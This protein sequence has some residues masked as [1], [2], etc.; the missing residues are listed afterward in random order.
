MKKKILSVL[1]VLTLIF[2]LSACGSK[3]DSNSGSSKDST[4]ITIG[5]NDWP[6]SYWWLAVN[7]L[8]YFKE[9]GVD[10]DV[11]LFSNY[12]DGLS[13]LNSGKIDL[14]VPGLADIIPGF[15][16][17]ADIKV[18]MVQDY[19]AGADG[20][21]AKSDIKSVKDLKGKNI[22]I[23][24]GGSDHLLLLKTLENAGL[25]P[26]KDV[27]I[28][29][30]STGD[31]A[32]AF[33]GGSVDAAAIWEP[34][35]SMAQAETGGNILSNSGD[36]EYEG[37]IPAVLAANGDSLKNKRDAIKSVMKA[38]YNARDGYENNYDEFAA[39]VAK[40][41]D[42][43]ADEFTELMKGCDVRTMEQTGEAFEDG[44][45]YVSL[46]YCADMLSG[47]LVDNGLIDE[48][49]SNLDDL[50]DSSVYD[51]VRSELEK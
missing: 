14:F 8:G 10:V 32:N 28:I 12:S 17:G 29:N 24:L 47:F 44:D 31:A 34:S 11:Q 16:S 26:E 40:H 42:I 39:A 30:M 48:K 21:I 18:L 36:K 22:A 41:T 7:E 2:S 50:F 1:L 5:I 46:K 33:I 4:K 23:E 38:W 43:T 3:G 9:E 35:L 13:A 51:E 27:N 19:S 20:V 49:P 25:D 15:T 37:L 6:G 45:T